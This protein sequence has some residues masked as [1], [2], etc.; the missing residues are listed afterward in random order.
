[1]VFYKVFVGY[2]R[3]L[4]KV[5]YKIRWPKRYSIGYS[6]RYCRRYSTGYVSGVCF[7]DFVLYMYPL[8]DR[9]QFVPG[10]PRS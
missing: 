10:V 4:H 2:F 8:L 5:F 9:L 6:T 7:K 1:M 3:E